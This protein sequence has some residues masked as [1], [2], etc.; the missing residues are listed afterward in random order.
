MK[1]KRLAVVQKDGFTLVELL[2]VVA[3]IATLAMIAIPEFQAYRQ[4]AYDKAAMAELTQLKAAAANVDANNIPQFWEWPVAKGAHPTLTG[5]SV[6]QN[7]TWYLWSFDF[8]SFGLGAGVLGYTCHVNGT[9]G[10]VM[11]APY[12]DS[13]IFAGWLDPYEIREGAAYRW[14]CW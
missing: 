4:K 12:T 3:V 11:F 14:P 2:V 7:V 1:K 13:S 9:T 6:G 8:T 10:Y 5:V